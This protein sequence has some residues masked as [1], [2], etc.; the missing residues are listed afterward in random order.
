MVANNNLYD[1]K[2]TQLIDSIKNNDNENISDE[3][4]YKNKISILNKIK[5][6]NEKPENQNRLSEKEH[7]VKTFLLKSLPM[8]AVFALI[9]TLSIVVY[10]RTISSHQQKAISLSG[11]SNNNT[12]KTNEDVVINDNEIE[13]VITYISSMN[14][15]TEEY[16]D[17][18]ALNWY[19]N[20]NEQTAVAGIK[21]DNLS[22]ESKYDIEEIL[23]DVEDVLNKQNSNDD[24]KYYVDTILSDYDSTL[25]LISY[26]TNN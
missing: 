1:E 9:L 16:E 20:N 15:A 10:N 8:V 19:E 4:L 3:R 22:L 6:I 13:T 7:N 14:A 12:N 11:E 25:T 23:K 26:N 24:D 17:D 5:H 18:V 21:L 2:F